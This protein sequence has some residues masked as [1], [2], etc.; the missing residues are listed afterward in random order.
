VTG[1]WL[2]E[3]LADSVQEQFSRFVDVAAWP[4]N[5][6]SSPLTVRIRGLICPAEKQDPSV[7]DIHSGCNVLLGKVNTVVDRCDM[8]WRDPASG[9]RELGMLNC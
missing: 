1:S 3:E 7:K 4:N 9:E 6:S 2:R 8:F 5:S